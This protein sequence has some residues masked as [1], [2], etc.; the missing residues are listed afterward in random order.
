M[1]NV[2]VCFSMEHENFK[3]KRQERLEVM[4]NGMVKEMIT[5]K[6][7]TEEIPKT[8]GENL[9]DGEVDDQSTENSDPGGN[10]VSAPEG[11]SHSRRRR[12]RSPT[13]GNKR[14]RSISPDDRRHRTKPRQKSPP[15]RSQNEDRPNRRRSPRKSEPFDRSSEPSRSRSSHYS[16]RFKY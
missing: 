12:S 4:A 2:S 7:L 10:K 15:R 11:H 5:P 3:L 14:K 9:E 13:N 16:S 1:G 6:E 8:S